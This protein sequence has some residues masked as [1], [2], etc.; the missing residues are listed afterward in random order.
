MIK[1][2]A[3]PPIP[4]ETQRI[5]RKAFRKGNRYL[6][7]RDEM[8]SLLQSEGYARLYSSQGQPGLSP[9]E[10]NLLLVVEQMEGLS[11]RNVVE[12]VV[13]RID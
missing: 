6:T 1:L 2:E 12:A 5:A 8:G 4:E 9:L 10:L 7:L 13:S 3:L 11:D